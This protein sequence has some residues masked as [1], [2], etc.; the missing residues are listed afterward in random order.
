MRKYLETSGFTN[1]VRGPL[2]FGNNHI[3]IQ[4]MYL[5][6]PVKEP[7]GTIRLKTTATIVK[8]N[9]DLF[10]GQCPMK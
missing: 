10:H 8:D 5:Q 6:T 7:D 4:N 2:K 9:Q 3:P 1:S